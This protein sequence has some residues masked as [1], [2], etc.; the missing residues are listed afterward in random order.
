M[1]FTA[2]TIFA[3]GFMVFAIALGFGYFQKFAPNVR[4]AEVYNKWG[5]QLDAE[6]AKMNAARKRVED[7]KAEVKRIS[8]NWQGTVATK[9]PSTS[10]A[11]GG[12]NLSV[13]PYDLTVDAR[14]FRD[15]VQRA[16]NRQLKSG[17]VTVITGPAIPTPPE[18]PETLLTTYFNYPNTPYPVAIYD[19]GSVEVRG[20]Y[21]QIME[22]VRAWSRMPNYLAVADGLVISGTQP[23]LTGRYNVTVVAFVRGKKIAPSVQMAR[24]AAAG[25]VA[26]QPGQPAAPASPVGQVQP[27]GGRAEEER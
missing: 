25:A 27:I 21:A 22:N 23:L 9:T 14:T 12:I 10:V 17:G 8:D 13:N 18:D 11:G 20:T 24:T 7:A 1:K 26:G 5:Q 15:S 2:G 19:L 6:G 4:D 3:L 16:V